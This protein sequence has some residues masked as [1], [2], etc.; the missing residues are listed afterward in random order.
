MIFIKDKRFYIPA[1]FILLF[2]LILQTGIYS[3]I[4]KK[5]SYASTAFQVTEHAINSK[6]VLK[7]LPQPLALET[8]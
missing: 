3:H 6:N 1:L 4:L 7:I 5:N 8:P 2:E